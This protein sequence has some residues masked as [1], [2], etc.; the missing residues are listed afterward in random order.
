MRLK[1]LIGFLLLLL[2][3]CPTAYAQSANDILG[4]YWSPEKDGK[5]KIFKD[6][7]AYHGKLIWTSMPKKDVNNPDEDL[8]ERDV[9]GIVFLKDFVYKDGKYRDG[10]IYDPKSGKTY[11]CEMWLEQGDLN[12]R[13]YIGFSFLGRTETFKRIE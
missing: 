6:S 10:E 1:L 11:S 8:R 7:G 4:T 9:E 13:G 2:Y 5:I 12:V 3:C